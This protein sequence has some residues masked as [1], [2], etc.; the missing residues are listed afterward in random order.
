MQLHRWFD[1][2]KNILEIQLITGR[3]HQ[4]RCILAFYKCSIIGDFKYGA[5]RTNNQAIELIAH[6]LLFKNFTDHL[7]YLNEKEFKTKHSF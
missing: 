6:K 7:N 1:Q 2:E 5:K 4:I 3:K